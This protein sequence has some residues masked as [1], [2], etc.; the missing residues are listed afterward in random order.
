MRQIKVQFSLDFPFHSA[1]HEQKPRD[2]SKFVTKKLQP[3][4]MSASFMETYF[5]MQSYH[6]VFQK[7]SQ[8]GISVSKIKRKQQK[9][10]RKIAHA[11]LQWLSLSLKYRSLVHLRV[12]FNEFRGITT[13][14]FAWFSTEKM[15]RKMRRAAG[16][17]ICVKVDF[18][19]LKPRF[20]SFHRLIKSNHDL[21]ER[22]VIIFS[23][24]CPHMS[25]R[26]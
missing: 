7:S 14:G 9:P 25:S 26:Q 6:D 10:T 11:G 16:S 4:Q 2:L 8:V 12:R 1:E 18:C 21:N 3:I 19:L 15:E 24:L 23:S 13:N 5:F 20:I 17:G 22:N